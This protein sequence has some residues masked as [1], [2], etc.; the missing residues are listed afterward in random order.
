MNNHYNYG[1]DDTNTNYSHRQ[2]L[3]DNNVN[4]NNSSCLLQ[5]PIVDYYGE[6][7]FNQTSSRHI[8]LYN[9]HLYQDNT[10]QF[11]RYNVPSSTPSNQSR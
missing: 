4:V 8:S 9:N 7:S 6:E 1:I 11:Y 10:N 5:S 3:S 2:Q